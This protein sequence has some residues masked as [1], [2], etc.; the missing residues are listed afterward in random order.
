[1]LLKKHLLVVMLIAAS[2]VAESRAKSAWALPTTAL[3][4]DPALQRAV[5]EGLIRYYFPSGSADRIIAISI[6]E[7]GGVHT[8][9][10]GELLPNREGSSARGA[11]QILMRVHEANARNRGLD[12]KNNVLHYVQYARFIYDEDR[13]RGGN[14]LRPWNPS[15]HCWSPQQSRRAM[16]A[17]S[18]SVATRQVA[19]AR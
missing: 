17:R 9:A 12:I 19:H 3:P 8:R 13:R 14:G 1:M 4:P 5:M 7:S 18:R 16:V 11:L 10:Q 2:L 6:C 15:Q